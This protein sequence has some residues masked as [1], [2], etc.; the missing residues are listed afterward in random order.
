M[1]TITLETVKFWKPCW[2]YEEGGLERLKKAY[3]GRENWT[4]LDI[5]NDMPGRGIS[6]RDILWTLFHEELFSRRDFVLIALTIAEPAVVKHWGKSTDRHPMDCVATIKRWLNGDATDEEL[7]AVA[8]AAVV[9]ADYA[10]R[11]AVAR[12]DAVYGARAAADYAARAAAARAAADYAACAAR[13]AARAAN[14][15]AAADYAVRAVRAAARAAADVA[16]GAAAVYAVAAARAAADYAA[17][18][19]RAAARAAHAAARVAAVYARAEHEQVA[20]IKRLI[21]EGKIGKKT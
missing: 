14:A 12:A 11:A 15:R 13:A 19:A 2:L 1:K 5:I 21:E 18:A 7:K 4:A 17:R 20:T 16:D 6:D 9:A 10:A 8:D 3:A